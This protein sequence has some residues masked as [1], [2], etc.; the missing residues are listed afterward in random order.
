MLFRSKEERKE[1]RE[2]KRKTKR[3]LKNREKG[4]IIT[5]CHRRKKNWGKRG[6]LFLK[7]HLDSLKNANLLS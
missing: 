2:G 6:L 5:G 3:F 1:W 7:G 4:K